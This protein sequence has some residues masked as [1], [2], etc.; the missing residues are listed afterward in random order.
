MDKKRNKM[1]ASGAACLSLTLLFSLDTLVNTHVFPLFYSFAPQA[2]D[3]A[4]IVGALTLFAI[5]GIAMRRPFPF[6]SLKMALSF[7]CAAAA[8]LGCIILGALWE[9]ALITFAGAV[10]LSVGG[11][12]VVPL[13]ACFTLVRLDYLRAYTVLLAALVAQYPLAFAVGLLPEHIVFAYVLAAPFASL[14]LAHAGGASTMLRTRGRQRLGDLSIANPRS[15][16]PLSHIVFLT[17]AF[18]NLATGCALTYLADGGIP[19]N[20]EFSILPLAAL[21]V[22]AT[23]GRRLDGDALVK[24][25]CLLILCGFLVVPLAGLP[26]NAA[27]GLSLSS[28]WLFAAGSTCFTFVFYLVLSEIGRRNRFGS[29]P[30]FAIGYGVSRIGFEVGALV[31]HLMNSSADAAVIASVALSFLFASYGILLLG[32]V[33]FRTLIEDVRPVSETDTDDRV[34]IER[35]LSEQCERAIER[36]GLTPRESEIVKLL[37]QG[38]SIAIIQEKLFVSKNT[39]KTHVKNIYMKLDVHSQQELIDRIRTLP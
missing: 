33:S 28:P 27:R 16:I 4:T 39:V 21:L 14:L 32:K 37:A 30:L 9:S 11:R 2:K 18:F 23:A 35:E 7:A 25:S 17:F 19:Q 12:T 8:G 1:L 36:Y 20:A 3:A 15:F 34:A 29:V 38:R 31:G 24:L 10:L 13:F 26:N 6:I 5:A 22:A